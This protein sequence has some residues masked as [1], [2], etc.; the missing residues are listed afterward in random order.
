MFNLREKSDSLE[1]AISGD[2]FIGGTVTLWSVWEEALYSHPLFNTLVKNLAIIF[3][4]SFS[5]ITPVHYLDLLTVPFYTVL[6][7]ISIFPSPIPLF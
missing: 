1:R 6:Q 3:D 2:K 5:L 7:A 4:P